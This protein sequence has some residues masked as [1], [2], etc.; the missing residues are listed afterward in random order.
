ML[1]ITIGEFN[2]FHVVLPLSTDRGAKLLYAAPKGFQ[3]CDSDGS[4]DDDLLDRTWANY[5]ASADW[6]QSGIDGFAIRQSQDGF[7]LVV[8][9]WVKPEGLEAFD[10]TAEHK[11]LSLSNRLGVAALVRQVLN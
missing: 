2:A 3:L 1:S 10:Y 5:E 4:W 11:E 7:E 8:S 6:Y 9:G